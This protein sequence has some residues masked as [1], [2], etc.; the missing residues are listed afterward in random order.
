MGIGKRAV[1]WLALA[2]LTFY[3]LELAGQNKKQSFPPP[4]FRVGVETVFLKVSVTDPLNRYVT[5]LEKEHFRVFE[6]K[7]EQE[8]THFS[9]QTAPISAGII[10][11][12]SASMKDNN[13]IKKAKNAILRFLKEGNSEDEYFLVTFNQSAKLVQK[14][15]G[16]AGALQS[17]AAF[18]KPGGQTA[19]YDAVYLALDQIKQA[20][21]EKKALILITDGEDNSSRYSPNDVR[22]FAK[23]SDVQVYAIGEQGMLGYGQNE[24]LKIVSLTGGRSYF[25]NSFSDLEYYIDLIHGELR[26]QYILGYVPSN[27]IHDGKWR[28][29]RIRLDAPQGL[30]KLSIHVKEGYYAPKD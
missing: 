17:E 7:I 29:I 10:F 18:Q 1:L 3:S 11:D 21:N 4:I 6:D 13:N 24:I 5:G 25:P 28:Q 12:V 14:F 15:T 19:I 26:N 27:K 9:Q 23:E 20:K 16:Q 22:E 30:P 8:L 2:V